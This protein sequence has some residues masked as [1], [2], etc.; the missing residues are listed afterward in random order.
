MAY[1]KFDDIALPAPPTFETG[2]YLTFVSDKLPPFFKQQYFALLDLLTSLQSE[3]V[4][5]NEQI[6]DLSAEKISSNTQFT[7]N[8][9]VGAESK[10]ALDGPNNKISIYDAQSTPIERIKIGKL[11]SASNEYGIQVKDAAGTVRFLTGSTT[12]VDG[13]ILKSNTVT[14][15]AIAAGTITATELAADSVTADEINVGNL[16]A[17]NANMGSITAGSIDG[18]TITGTTITG[19][20]VRTAS[21]GARV[22]IT[23]A[24]LDGYNAA[25]TQTLD[26]GVDGTLRVGPSSGNNLYWNNSNLVLTGGIITTG[27][28]VEGAAANA[29]TGAVNAITNMTTSGE[30][31]TT[32]TVAETSVAN[33]EL[34]TVGRKVLL[35]FTIELKCWNSTGSTNLEEFDW[36]L[37]IRKNDGSSTGTSGALVGEA[38]IR[39]QGISEGIAASTFYFT[40]GQAIAVDGEPNGSVASPSTTHYHFTLQCASMKISGGLGSYNNLIGLV[41][42]QVT[43]VELR[44]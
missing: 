4:V 16:A 27:N 19:G 28:L 44:R 20:I 14:A 5:T 39:N 13:G 18:A 25:G 32:T 29:T 8:V 26:F 15:D 22:Q 12:Y 34:D 37:K 21:S 1:S 40:R 38:Y 35:F 9:Y 11:G 36:L 33:I 30:T 42:G 17:I 24:G 41:S 2:E 10:I 6:F 7:N 23:S 31:T 3:F 43:A